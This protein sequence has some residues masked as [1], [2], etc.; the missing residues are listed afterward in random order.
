MNMVITKQWLLDNRTKRGS[1]TKIQANI[2]DLDYPLKK[3]WMQ[4][5]IGREISKE[6]S[7]L[8]EQGKDKH[9]YNKLVKAMNI[10]RSLSIEEKINFKKWLLENS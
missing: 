10:Y 1:W 7:I 8:F 9:C 3:G 2:L 5:V 6:K 4:L